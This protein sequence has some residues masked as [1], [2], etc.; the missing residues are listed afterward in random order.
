MV[1]S[2]GRAKTTETETNGGGTKEIRMKVETQESLS[3]WRRPR[4]NT[5]ENTSP[6]PKRQNNVA[7]KT[8]IR[9]RVTENR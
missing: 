8:I 2:N 1:V 7:R 3:A 9:V 4:H 5:G 6:D